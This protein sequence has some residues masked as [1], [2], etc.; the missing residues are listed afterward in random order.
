MELNDKDI[1][2][3]SFKCFVSDIPDKFDEVGTRFLGEPVI[4]AE[5]VD[6]DNFLME[7]GEKIYT[8]LNLTQ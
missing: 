6:F 4:N 2:Q 5:R 3:G 8:P 7:K 1:S